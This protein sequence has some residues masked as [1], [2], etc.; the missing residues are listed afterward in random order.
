MENPYEINQRLHR[1]NAE[2]DDIIAMGR[3]SLTDVREQNSALERIRNGVSGSLSQLGVSAD[4]VERIER[5]MW[6]DRVI[7]GVGATF[8]LLV[9]WA[10]LRWL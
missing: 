10:I 4:T 6:Q 9:L 3:A 1:S 7:F 8:T 2:L 5:V